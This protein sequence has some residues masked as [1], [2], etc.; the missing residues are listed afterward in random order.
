MVLSE[1]QTTITYNLEDIDE[2][3]CILGTRGGAE[4]QM[5][6]LGQISFCLWHKGAYNIVFLCMDTLTYAIKAKIAPS[7]DISDPIS[8][9]SY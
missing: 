4:V 8:D 1:N 5:V 7:R 3:R 6:A 9:N 2:V